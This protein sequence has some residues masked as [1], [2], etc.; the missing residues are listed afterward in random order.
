MGM[1][2]HSPGL[3]E[4]GCTGLGERLPESQGWCDLRIGT[5]S[6]VDAV[7]TARAPCAGFLISKAGQSPPFT[8]CW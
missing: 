1:G 8:R 4:S 7:P 5:Q 2:N 3:W 6:G